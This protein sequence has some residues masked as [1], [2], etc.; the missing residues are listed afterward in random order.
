MMRTLL[1]IIMFLWAMP[2]GF[3]QS[4]VPMPTPTSTPI[5]VPS[6]TPTPLSLTKEE[7]YRIANAYVDAN[8]PVD[9]KK[10]HELEAVYIAKDNEWVV[11]F[12]DY[13]PNAAPDGDFMVGVDAA[14]GKALG[15][16]GGRLKQEYRSYF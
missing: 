1:L 7:V 10:I 5:P 6:P 4:S 12:A 16:I 2:A 3:G 8:L 14:S 11:L 15:F 9:P 13:R